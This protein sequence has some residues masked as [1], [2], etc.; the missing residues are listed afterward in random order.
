MSA[1]RNFA[2]ASQGSETPDYV[3]FGLEGVALYR[4]PWKLVDPDSP[5]L[6]QIYRDPLESRDMAAEHPE[7]VEALSAAA[8]AW[9]RG[10]KLDRSFFDIFRDPDSFGGPED[11]APWADVAREHAE[12]D[13]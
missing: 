8:R 10:P 2:F 13:S 9:P 12:S 6:F 3:T 11:R 7:I 4:P 1:L 5:K